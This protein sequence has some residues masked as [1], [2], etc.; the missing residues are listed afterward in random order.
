MIPRARASR[1]P[2]SVADSALTPAERA[3]LVAL[4]ELGVRF[5]VVGLSAAALQGARVVTDDVD[6][7][8]ADREDPRIHEAVN[9]AGGVWIPGN[10]GMMPP[11][12]GGEALGDRFDVV[13][14]LSGLRD[15]DSEYAESRVVDLDGIAVR[16]L[17][18]ERIV[19]SKRAAARP[20]D[21]AAL[22]ALE[23]ALAVGEDEAKPR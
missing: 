3:L 19:H 12:I 4:D 13:L 11:M 14:T 1:E 2:F 5:L 6:L 9:R 21:L 17:P 20:K 7:W 10:F 15:F 18:L 23:A 8:F 16:V 22:P